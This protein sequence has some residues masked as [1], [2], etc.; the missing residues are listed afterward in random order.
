MKTI[1]LRINGGKRRVEAD[2]NRTLLSL[3]GGDLDLTGAKLGC[4]DRT[5]VS[6]KQKY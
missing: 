3:L 6:I 1:E 5:S 4:G 2:A